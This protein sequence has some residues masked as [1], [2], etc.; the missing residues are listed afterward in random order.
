MKVAIVLILAVI[1]VAAAYRPAPYS[2]YV[3]PSRAEWRKSFAQD[4]EESDYIGRPRCVCF[5]APCPCAGYDDAAESDSEFFKKIGSFFKKYVT[6]ENI[7]KGMSIYNT[8]KGRDAVESDRSIRDEEEEESDEYYS[9][10]A[11]TYYVDRATGWRR[12]IS[13]CRDDEEEADQRN[14]FNVGGTYQGGNLG[15]NANYGRTFNGGNLNIGGGYQTGSG[16]NANLGVNREWNQGRTSFGGNAGWSQGGGANVGVTFSHRWDDEEEADRFDWGKIF[17]YAQ[18]AKNVYDIIK[19][20]EDFDEEADAE[21]FK[22]IGA[23]FKKNFNAEN[24]QK[25]LDIYRTIKGGDDMAES[26]AEFLKKLGSI[27]KKGFGLYQ[28]YGGLLRI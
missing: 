14:T 9:R 10:N 5:R 19:S 13:N 23:F 2:P 11:P 27:A 8:I 7:Q 15:V 21:F 16:F 18:K 3:W 28:Q 1:A 25:G 26:D 4:D 12:C 6:P 24:I 22:K 20:R 17:D